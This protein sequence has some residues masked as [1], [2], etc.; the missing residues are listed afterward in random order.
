MSIPDD[1]RAD[2]ALMQRYVAGEASAFAILYGRHKDGVWRY[3]LRGSQNE[4]VAA[5]MAQDVWASVIKSRHGYEP[6]ARFATWLYRLAHNRLVDHWRAERPQEELDAADEIAAPE[7]H[8]PAA[9]ATQAEQGARLMQALNALAPEQRDAFLL[10][11]EGGLSLEEIAAAQGVGRETVKSRLR[12]AL[13]K[14]RGELADVW[15]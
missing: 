4:A 9:R 12:Y 14:L 13:A 11:V 10:Q 2:E 6:R 8:T 1:L 5:E 3:L 15:P 7:H